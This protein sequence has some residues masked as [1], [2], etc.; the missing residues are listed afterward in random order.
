MTTEPLR[1][2]ETTWP[3]PSAEL[4]DDADAYQLPD[5]AAQLVFEADDPDGVNV[6]SDTV[7]VTVSL[8]LGPILGTL[9]LVVPVPIATLRK[10]YCAAAWHT[11]EDGERMAWVPGREHVT[12]VTAPGP[13]GLTEIRSTGGT[14][15]VAA[16]H[17]HRLRTFETRA[18]L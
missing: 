13:D 18:D 15:R 2:H 3:L 11:I 1:P 16:A 17:L 7:H 9:D 6:G 10:A 12:V 4:F 8:D 5:G 14:H